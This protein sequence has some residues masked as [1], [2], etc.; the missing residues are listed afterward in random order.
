MQQT[1]HLEL[2]PEAYYPPKERLVSEL[3]RQF[4]LGYTVVIQYS[5]SHCVLNMFS[6]IVYELFTFYV[7]G[8]GSQ[9]DTMEASKRGDVKAVQE[10]LMSDPSQCRTPNADGATP[11]MV[12]A[13]MGHFQVSTGISLFY[14]HYVL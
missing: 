14:I 11:L 9:C 12:A 1:G 3:L 2:P 4:V 6:N 13:M 7:C 5:Y 10:I 8:T